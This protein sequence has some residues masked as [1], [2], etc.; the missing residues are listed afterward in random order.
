[1]H[2]LVPMSCLPL[3]AIILPKLPVMYGALL[4][5]AVIVLMGVR[6]GSYFARLTG[7][8]RWVWLSLA[9]LYSWFT[10]GEYIAATLT[11]LPVTYEGVLGGA[12]Q[13]LHL[14]A[15]L[16]MLSFILERYTPVQ[17]LAGLYQWLHAWHFPAE[18]L[19]RTVARMMLVLEMQLT[20]PPLRLD[21]W[22][23]YFAQ[24]EQL[25]AS[26]PTPRVVTLPCIALTLAE[27]LQVSLILSATVIAL[28]FGVS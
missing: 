5:L 20:M 24:P 12:M 27:R 3:L 13:I 15:I 19:Q 25:C 10:P 14:L 17:L 22:T 11:W 8:L 21:R 2:V 23:A 1:M 28:F 6:A 7:R 18:P 26:M 16:S 4:S 9:I